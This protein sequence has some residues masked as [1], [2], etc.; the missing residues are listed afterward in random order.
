MLLT[1]K[2]QRPSLNKLRKVMN[3]NRFNDA[4]IERTVTRSP[5]MCSVFLSRKKS[6]TSV[7][8]DFKSEVQ[9]LN[10]SGL[11]RAETLFSG[12]KWEDELCVHSAQLGL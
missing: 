12:F 7:S 1:S 9:D 10:V 3:S 4:V 6:F 5:A 2:V 11:R 8:R